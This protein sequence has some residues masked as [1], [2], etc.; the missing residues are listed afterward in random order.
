[1]SDVEALLAERAGYIARGRK[2]RA[3]QVA[4]VLKGYGIAVDDEVE[5]ATAGPEETA[6]RRGPGRPRKG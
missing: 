6:V 4:E 3:A 2:D 1:M 5:E